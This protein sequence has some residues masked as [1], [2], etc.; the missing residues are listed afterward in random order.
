MRLALLGALLI[1]RTA[2]QSGKDPT[3]DVCRRHKHQTCIIDSILYI[4][5]GVAYYGGSVGNDSKTELSKLTLHQSTLLIDPHRHLPFVG[6]CI[7]SNGN[8][9]EIPG[10]E[11][12]DKGILP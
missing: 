4:D 8:R 3:R 2:Q 1:V 10:A 11:R 7:S 12:F 5:G 9:W 6:G